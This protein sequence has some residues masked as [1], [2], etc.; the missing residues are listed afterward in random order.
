[1]AF[2]DT[3]E[4]LS[5]H[6]SVKIHIGNAPIELNVAHIYLGMCF[7]VGATHVLFDFVHFLILPLAKHIY[8]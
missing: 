4:Y 7:V 6:V 3:Y 1:M 5:I 8:I 2:Q